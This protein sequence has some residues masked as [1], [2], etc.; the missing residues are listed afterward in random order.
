MATLEHGDTR[1]E[2]ISLIDGLPDS[3]LHAVKRYIQYIRDLQDP[4]LNA[5][6]EAPWDDEPLTDEDLEAIAE[7]KEDIVAG[8]VISAEELKRELGI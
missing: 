6:A 3:E 2:I 4:F 5:L 1:R 7:S 8:R